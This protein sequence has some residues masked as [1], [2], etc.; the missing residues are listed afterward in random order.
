MKDS[1]NLKLHFARYLELIKIS[2]RSY[3]LITRH[4]RN[5]DRI[6][7]IKDAL[8]APETNLVINFPVYF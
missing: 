3:N 7:G 8:P 2:V 5:V 1:T 4:M 6:I